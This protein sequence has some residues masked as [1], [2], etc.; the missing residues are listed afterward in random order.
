MSPSIGTPLGFSPDT[1]KLRDQA[2]TEIWQELRAKK[3]KS[4]RKTSP[5]RL[6]DVPIIRRVRPSTI[7][8]RSPELAA[9]DYTAPAGLLAITGRGSE[10]YRRFAT[11]AEA[12]RYAIELLPVPLLR[13][14]ILE[15]GREWFGGEQIRQLYDNPAYPLSRL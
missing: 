11:G 2:F 12:I 15:I 3:I 4:P 6:V 5:S 14:S 10:R 9:F 13:W 1:L 8:H 7:P